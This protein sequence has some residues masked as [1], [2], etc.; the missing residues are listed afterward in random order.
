MQKIN[1]SEITII[2]ISP[3]TKG[4]VAFVSFVIDGIYKIQDVMIGTSLKRNNFR[5]IYPI[6]NI[7]TGAT[8]QVFYPIKKEIGEQIENIVLS[9]YDKFIEKVK[10]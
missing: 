10:N 9:A 3:S 4:I 8:I 2:P 1:I 5:L 6:K 7:P